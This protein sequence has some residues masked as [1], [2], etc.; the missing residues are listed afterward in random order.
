MFCENVLEF[1][2][3]GQPLLPDSVGV[4]KLLIGFLYMTMVGTTIFWIHH[5]ERMARKGDDGAVKSVIFPVFTKMMWMSA[6]SS[7][8]IGVLLIFVPVNV[9][10]SN[11]GIEALLYPLAWSFQHA[12]IEGIPFLLMQKGCGKNAAKRAG[13]QTLLWCLLTFLMQ[14]VVYYYGGM[15]S[16][17]AQGAWSVI[18]LVFYFALWKLPRHRLFRRP[19]AILYAQFWFWFRVM[20]LIVFTCALSGNIL[21]RQIGECGYVFG[22]L[23]LFALLQPGMSYWCL[24]QDSRWWQGLAISQGSHRLSSDTLLSPLL[25]ADIS[26]QSAQTLAHTMDA[27][28]REGSRLLN[29]ANIYLDKTSILGHGSFSKVYR[30]VFE[31][32]NSTIM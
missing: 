3:I 4:I 32:C 15:I 25:G 22:P 24:L 1:Y 19:A 31:I 27:L 12:V 23:L 20:V 11:D 18:I 7:F 28:G 5:Q 17:V 30:W 8:Y 16:I 21:L 26:L 29:F 9:T 14:V 2:P 10:R 6:F 13:L